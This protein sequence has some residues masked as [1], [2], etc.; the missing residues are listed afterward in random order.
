MVEAGGECWTP[1]MRPLR[2]PR[3]V[4]FEYQWF[5]LPL[6]LIRNIRWWK[7]SEA[8]KKS[9]GTHLIKLKQAIKSLSKTFLMLTLTHALSCSG[10]TQNFNF[11]IFCSS[12]CGRRTGFC[13]ANTPSS[14]HPQASMLLLPPPGVSGPD[15]CTADSY[16]PF[17]SQIKCC[18]LWDDF[19]DSKIVIFNVLLLYFVFLL[20]LIISD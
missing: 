15:L 3:G 8:K 16:L 6:R 9:Q 13:S 20:A 11:Q 19:L 12:L 17:R 18:L 14:P 7:S 1:S 4:Q 10:A 5:S 2:G